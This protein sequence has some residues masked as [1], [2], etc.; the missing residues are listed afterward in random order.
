MK[1]GEHAEYTLLERK[2]KEE[3]L[4]GATLYVT[5]EPCT[6]RNEPKIECAQRVIERRVK[7]V[8]IGMLDPNPVIIGTGQRR[9]RD[10]GIEVGLFEPDLMAAIE[11][12]NRDFIRQHNPDT[13]HKKTYVDVVDPVEPGHKGPNG[14]PIGYNDEG[15]KV[16]WIPDDE[17]PGQEFALLLRRNDRSIQEA[18]DEFWDKVWWNRH[19]LWCDRIE[20]GE[21]ELTDSQRSGF[22]R[23][24]R[25]AERIE[26][27][28]GIES[29][30]LDDFEWGLLNGRLSALAWAMG[31]DWDESLDT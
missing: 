10:A 18:R 8:Y 31:A 5:L 22:E 21:E 26:R 27:E 25:A 1:P 29:L 7:K 15:D 11:E 16:E 23:A 30:E 13:R 4:A 24:E 17:N 3:T 9:L 2:L 20:A 12:L 28:Y 19:K 6:Q 14:Y